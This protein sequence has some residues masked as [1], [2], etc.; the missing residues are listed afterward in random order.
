MKPSHFT[1]PRT[2][3]EATFYSWGAALELEPKPTMDWQ[4]KVAIIA[5]VIACIA[6]VAIINYWG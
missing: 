2:M 5:S 6:C 4:D 1:T 3:S